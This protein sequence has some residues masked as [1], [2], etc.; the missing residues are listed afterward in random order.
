MPNL[1]PR[2]QSHDEDHQED[3][4]TKTLTRPQHKIKKPDMYK[5]FLLNDDYTPMEFVVVILMRFFKKSEMDASQIML[6]VHH[7][8]RGIAGV[9][10]HEV[11]ETKVMQVNAFSK[12]H[13]YP[14]KCAME[15]D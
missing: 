7:K 12:N 11:A 2:S 6:E 10:S 3:G 8:G 5:V 15:K 14:L 9:F 1:V 13:K 4:Q